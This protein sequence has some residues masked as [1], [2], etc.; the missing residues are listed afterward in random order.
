LGL[1]IAERAVR[2]HSGSIRATTLKG[3][4]GLDVEIIL[5]AVE[6]SSRNGER[7]EKVQLVMS[8]S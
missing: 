1:A 2:L 5:P 8:G 6:V 7:A 4:S 3:Q